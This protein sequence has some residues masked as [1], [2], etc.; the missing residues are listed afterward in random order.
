MR[1][2]YDWKMELYWRLPVRLQETALSLYAARLDKRYYGPAHDKFLEELKERQEWSTA[3]FQQWQSQRLQYI[4][5]LA[6]TKVPYYREQWRQLDWRSVRS[7]AD[8]SVLPPLHK[9]SIRQNERNFIVEGMDPNSLWVEWHY[10]KR[11]TH[12]LAKLDGAAILGFDGTDGTKRCRSGSRHAPG[13]DGRP[14]CRSRD[15]DYATILAFQSTMAATVFIELSRVFAHRALLRRCPAKI[16][17][18]MDH[19]IWL[20][21]SRTCRSCAGR[22]N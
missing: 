3:E 21:H 17:I 6:A 4:V 20:C 9:Q 14:P 5:E 1:R 7:A 15:N 22:W 16:S 19:G 11:I 18:G 2:V 8:L 12:L 13:D 10:R